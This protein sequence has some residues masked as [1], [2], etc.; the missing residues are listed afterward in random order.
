MNKIVWSER[1]VWNNRT[2][3]VHYLEDFKT[4]RE[5]PIR[6]RLDEVTDKYLNRLIELFVNHEDETIKAQIQ[7]ELWLENV[8]SVLYNN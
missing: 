1:M 3:A 6:Y 7:W 4:I 8:N 2:L 5:T